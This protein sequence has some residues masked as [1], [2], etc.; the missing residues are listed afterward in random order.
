MV[1]SQFNDWDHRNNRNPLRDACNNALLGLIKPPAKPVVM[2]IHP[3]QKAGSPTRFARK[4]AGCVKCAQLSFIQ[5][6]KK[7]F[8]RRGRYKTQGKLD[9]EG[10]SPLRWRVYGYVTAVQGDNVLG[11]G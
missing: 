8:F 6:D 7:R 4:S 10:C 9:N 1:Q 11:D 5:S 3:R 2:T